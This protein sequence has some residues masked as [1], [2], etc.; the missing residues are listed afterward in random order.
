MFGGNPVPQ[1]KANFLW[2]QATVFALNKR[3]DSD[4]QTVSGSTALHAGSLKGWG[5]GM[6]TSGQEGVSNLDLDVVDS[7]SD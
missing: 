3:L 1:L 4:Q 2:V 7:G 5:G 6:F